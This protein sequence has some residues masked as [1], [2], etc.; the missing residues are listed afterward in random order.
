VR[1]RVRACVLMYVRVCVCAHVC[2]CVS[3]HVCA[4]VCVCARACV[5]AYEC[6]CACA[7][8]WVGACGVRRSGGLRRAQERVRARK[9]AQGRA[10]RQARLQGFAQIWPKSH[11]HCAV[12]PHLPV[13]SSPWAHAWLCTPAPQN[14]CAPHCCLSPAAA[15]V[16]IIYLHL[17]THG[18]DFPFTT[19]LQHGMQV[20]CMCVRA[21]KCGTCWCG[22][23]REAHAGAADGGLPHAGAADGGLPH[24]GAAVS[25]RHM[26]VVQMA[27]WHG[28]CLCGTYHRGKAV[29]RHERRRTYGHA[30]SELPSQ[31]PSA[32]P[33]QRTAAGRGRRCM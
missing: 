11:G 14:S 5:R 19:L 6:V 32:P 31:L 25:V 12:L 21:R 27:A 7:R 20:R 18:R 3:M 26:L 15:G 10:D 1:A 9:N 28:T 16:G 33:P 24:A 4:R 30:L 13:D 17:H 23:E 29:H 2:A 8:A 22:S